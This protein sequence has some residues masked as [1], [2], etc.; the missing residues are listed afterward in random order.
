MNPDDVFSEKDYDAWIAEQAEI[1][2]NPPGDDAT[3]EE[4]IDWLVARKVMKL[5]REGFN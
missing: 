5:H 1:E 3:K 4:K 2:R